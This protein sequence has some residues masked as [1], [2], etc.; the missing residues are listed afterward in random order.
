MFADGMKGLI[1]GG[2][3]LGTGA[4]ASQMLGPGFGQ[5]VGMGAELGAGMGVLRTANQMTQPRPAER[6]PAAPAPS[7]V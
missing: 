7:M 4:E 5:L 3:L 2:L 1:G 6:A